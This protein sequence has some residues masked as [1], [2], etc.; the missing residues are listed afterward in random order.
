MSLDNER[1][2]KETL[3]GRVAGLEELIAQKGAEDNRLLLKIQELELKP[4]EMCAE[5]SDFY[6]PPKTKL[7]GELATAVE[8]RQRIEAQLQASK[9]LQDELERISSSSKENIL[10]AELKKTLVSFAKSRCSSVVGGSQASKK[11]KDGKKQQNKL[12]R[13]NK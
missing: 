1:T 5:L 10:S 6:E 11:G 2:A 8:L 12:I 9:V 4:C 13:I 3:K 7:D